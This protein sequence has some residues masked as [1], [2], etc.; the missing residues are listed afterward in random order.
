MEILVPEGPK[1]C[2][3]MGYLLSSEDV[4]LHHIHDNGAHY[5]QST[6]N[7]LRYIWVEKTPRPPFAELINIALTTA[8]LYFMT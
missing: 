6:Y 4:T 8:D 2:Q 3:F 1:S 7:P 5:F